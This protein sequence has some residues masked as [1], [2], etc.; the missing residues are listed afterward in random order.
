MVVKLIPESYILKR[1]TQQAITSDTDQVQN[2]QAPVEPVAHGMPLTGQKTSR[3]TNAS[4]SFA[5][6]A[7][8]GCT[9]DENYAVLENHIK[10]MQSEFE[11]IKKRKMANRQNT[12]ATE[13]GA[14]EG[15]QD[16]GAPLVLKNTGPGAF[17]PTGPSL[18]TTGVVV[19]PSSSNVG[20]PPKSK[21]KGRKNEKAHK[22]GMN[23]QAK[24]KNRCSV[25]RSYDHNAQR[26]PD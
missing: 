6:L 21:G 20:N 23:G 11:E 3:F 26:C 19:D 17:A 2:V 18:R 1:W 8:E 5:A 4:I 15:A 14:T 25:C 10:Q 24:R 22:K 16:P 9:S 7:V 12:G 13:G